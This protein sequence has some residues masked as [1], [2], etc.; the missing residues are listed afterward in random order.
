MVSTI[1]KILPK[2]SWYFYS[3]PG[4]NHSPLSG[5]LVSV[6]WSLFD[7]F[8]MAFIRQTLL[9][10]RNEQERCVCAWS[11]GC[12]QL[13]AT[14]WTTACRALLS[15]E[16]PRQE[17]CSGLLFPSPEDLSGPEMEPSSSELQ[18]VSCVAGS[19]FTD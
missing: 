16:F 17:H 13:F 3:F 14:P 19:F 12:L 1:R 10:L 2:M 9:V 7:L 18:A 4:E 5:K 11:L 6:M 15:I 8:L